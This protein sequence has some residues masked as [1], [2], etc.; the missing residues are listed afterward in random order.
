MI[1]A[2]RT[3]LFA[4]GAVVVVLQSAICNLQSAIGQEV[5]WRHDYNAAGQEAHARKRPILI[6]FG[7]ESCFWCKR[8]DA[9]TFRDAQVVK[10][11]NEK[12]IPL[13]IDAQRDAPLA[14]ALHIQSYPTLVFAD[15]DGR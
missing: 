8:L 3:W 10:L 11:L 4:I 14:D 6:D 9:S 13:K 2:H 7:T 1:P 5:Q 15:P 12:F